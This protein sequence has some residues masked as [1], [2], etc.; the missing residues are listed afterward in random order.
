MF[1]G[2]RSQHKGYRCLHTSTGNVY[3]FRNVVFDESRF[4]F[5]DPSTAQAF[6]LQDQ[7]SSQSQR[8]HK[9]LT[10]N[11]CMTDLNLDDGTGMDEA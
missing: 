4:P 2:Y 7:P 11:T 8:Q 5:A 6:K 9:Q 1:I 10:N 3:I